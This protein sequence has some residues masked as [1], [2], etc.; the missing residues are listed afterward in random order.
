MDRGAVG[1]Q[2]AGVDTKGISDGLQGGVGDAPLTRSI[3]RMVPS[4]TQAA[5]ES[6]CC[7]NFGRM[8]LR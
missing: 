3:F 7:D 4:A 2:A 1:P 5:S 6:C 8:T